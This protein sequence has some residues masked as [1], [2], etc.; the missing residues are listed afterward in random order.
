MQKYLRMARRHEKRLHADFG[1][2]KLL[3]RTLIV[4]LRDYCIEESDLSTKTLKKEM[5][6]RSLNRYLDDLDLDL[7]SEF[8]RSVSDTDSKLAK[9]L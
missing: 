4:S 9:L 6:I 7:E 8:T 2:P 5:P 3:N 1:R